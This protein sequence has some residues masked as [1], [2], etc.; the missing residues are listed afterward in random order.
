MHSKAISGLD[1]RI[2]LRKLVLL[3]ILSVLINFA[4]AKNC[5]H[6]SLPCA[7]PS[8]CFS[9]SMIIFSAKHVFV[10]NFQGKIMY[11]QSVDAFC[12]AEIVAKL[13]GERLST[14]SARITTRSAY[15]IEVFIKYVYQQLKFRTFFAQA[16][17][18]F[19]AT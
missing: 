12:N 17:C 10:S 16:R 8:L 1:E 7:F 3:E 14:F 15:C 6:C 4:N 19:F 11:L 18:N 2:L 9:P 5:K 13:K